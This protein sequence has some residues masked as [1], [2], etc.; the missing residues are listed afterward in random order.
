[1]NGQNNSVLM[2]GAGLSS[3]SLAL[4]L[5]DRGFNAPIVMM[6]RNKQIFPHKTWCFWGEDWLPDY[7]RPLVAKRWSRWQ[8]SS[9]QKSHEHVSDSR[10][11]DYCCIRAEDF[12]QFANDQFLKSKNVSLLFEQECKTLAP[13]HGQIRVQH[14]GEILSGKY[15][16]NSGYVLPESMTNGLFQC[17]TGAWIT[18][19]KP[20]F[21]PNKAG[22]MLDLK[23]HNGVI[24]F[25]YTLP[26]TETEALW[27]LTYFS[28]CIE[29]LALMQQRT[30]DALALQFGVDKYRIERW[31]QGMLPMTT[32]IKKAAPESHNGWHAIGTAG[33]MM[34]AATGYAFLPIQRWSQ[35][36]ANAIING[37]SA[38][39]ENAIPSKYNWLD[40][41]FLKVLRKQ[42]ALAPEIFM[43]MINGTSS[44][45]FSRFMT[46]RASSTDIAKVISVMPK[47]P[48]FSALL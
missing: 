44:Q 29:N 10:S 22:L 27:E 3:S 34:R 25:T 19:D 32:D 41:I 36:A 23:A 13:M 7:L 15:G 5:L 45:Q 24:E 30:K 31:E 38:A 20:Y 26:F 47:R 39:V 18:L 9:Q 2:I 6:E 43:R 46:E 16:F 40:D 1:M 35:A 21:E 37:K 48:F 42:P 14:N 4:A 33:G 8:I 12:Y 17:F 28:P 11:N